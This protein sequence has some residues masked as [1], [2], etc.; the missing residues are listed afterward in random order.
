MADL[1]F[2]MLQLLQEVQQEGARF[3]FPN[4]ESFK[5]LPENFNITIDE[6]IG[7]DKATGDLK[8]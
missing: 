8:E 5:L 2:S 1:T 3:I 7:Y 6:L 4:K